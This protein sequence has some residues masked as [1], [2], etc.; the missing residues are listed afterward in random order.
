MKKHNR[1]T[2][3]GT[4]TEVFLENGKSFL[5]DTDDWEELKRFFW[6]ESARG[7]IVSQA[8][9]DMR[10]HR[11]IMNPDDSMVVDHKNRNKL[12]NRKSNLRMVTQRINIINSGMKNTNKSGHAGVW[13][14]RKTNRYQAFITA[15]Y[16]KI[17][18]GCFLTYAEAVDARE[19]A[20][21]I[22]FTKV[23]AV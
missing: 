10:F 6:I 14:N 3:K 5:C 2:T 7:Y 20:E 15:N 22:Y 16:K 23:A 18:L 21:N 17:H 9:G 19:K 4:T 11:V 1:Y 12:D 13:F 8:N